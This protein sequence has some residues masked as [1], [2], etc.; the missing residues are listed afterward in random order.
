MP[1]PVCSCKK[2][3]IPFISALWISILR[4]VCFNFTSGSVSLSA[5][6]LILKL[7]A[8]GDTDTFYMTLNYMKTIIRRINISLLVAIA[9]LTISGLLLMATGKEKLSTSLFFVASITLP[10]LLATQGIEF[11][12]ENQIQKAFLFI[13]L[14]SLICIL[15]IIFVFA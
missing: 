1:K 8:P 12:I 11:M 10:L 15:S 6:F 2:T 7:N 14:L 9:V 13:L 3:A 4:I 5:F